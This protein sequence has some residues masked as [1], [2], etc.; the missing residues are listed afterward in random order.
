MRALLS[1]SLFLA[2]AFASAADPSLKLV[3]TNLQ[4]KDNSGWLAVRPQKADGQLASIQKEDLI[5]HVDG[6]KVNNFSVLRVRS[7]QNRAAVVFAIDVS[8]SMIARLSAV[9]TGVSAIAKKRLRK[10]DEV[11][12]VT[13]DSVPRVEARLGS[14][15]ASIQSRLKTLQ[16]SSVQGTALFD[17]VAEAQTELKSANSEAKAIFVVTDGGDTASKIRTDDL[18]KRA[19]D[20]K[21]RIFAIAVGPTEVDENLA[22]LAFVSNGA[23]VHAKKAADVAD[24]YDAAYASF[25]DEYLVKVPLGKASGKHQVFVEWKQSPREQLIVTLGEEA[26]SSLPPYVGILIGLV[27][28]GSIGAGVFL[29][30]KKTPKNSIPLP[31]TAW[32]NGQT[33]IETKISASIIETT[34]GD[35]TGEVYPG[36]D[37]PA[38]RPVPAA[39]P[40]E[41]PTMVKQPA[42]T[43]MLAWLIGV[44]GRD[45]GR[46]YQI[47]SD[48]VIFGR[49]SDAEIRSDDPEVSRHHA[50]FV[51][52]PNK[53]FSITDMASSGGTFINGQRQTHV[54]L[55]DGDRIQMGA[56]HFIFKTIT[57]PE[58]QR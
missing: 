42:T 5:V 36:I 30:R 41:R 1:V 25:S 54:A 33:G 6:K 14:S 19:T 55:R 9:R 8:G 51:A 50:K 48:E 7:P 18:I 39:C 57:D 37:A 10:Q 56:T 16:V 53:T 27:L 47:Q 31:E 13:F 22:R 46:Q 58:T 43:P 12:I 38:P 4:A 32:G 26:S 49:A 2:A 24:A 44:E 35:P 20:A 29:Q 17:G 52:G 40:V 11:G 28:V 34:L 15:L 23:Y 3:R 21:V 45:S